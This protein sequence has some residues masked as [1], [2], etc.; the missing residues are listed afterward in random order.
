MTALNENHQDNPMSRQEPEV[1]KRYDKR[2][3]DRLYN[4]AILS[5][6]TLDELSDMTLSGRRFIV[7]DAETGEDLTAKMLVSLH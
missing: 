1:I 6:V 7:R 2:P 4:T 5:Y 3:G